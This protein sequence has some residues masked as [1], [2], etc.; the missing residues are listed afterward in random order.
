[1]SF[2]RDVKRT[3]IFGLGCVGGVRGSGGPLAE[4]LLADARLLARKPQ[5]LSCGLLLPE[6]C[7][8]IVLLIGPAVTVE[9]DDATIRARVGALRSSGMSSRDI[10]AQVAR[11]IRQVVIKILLLI[12][13]CSRNRLLSRSPIWSPS[14][15]EAF[16]WDATMD[17]LSKHLLIL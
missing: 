5:T 11:G 9:P 12:C 2:P 8:Q 17:H 14:R 3:P 6:A 13:Y 16:R 1:M 10:A 7:R 4:Y 15:A